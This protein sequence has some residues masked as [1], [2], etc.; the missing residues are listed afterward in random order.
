[1]KKYGM[2]I[3][4]LVVIIITFSI[5]YYEN[6]NIPDISYHYPQVNFQSE[7]YGLIRNIQWSSWSDEQIF[8]LATQEDK[9]THKEMSKLYIMDVI[10]GRVRE[11]FEFPMHPI[12]KN[13]IQYSSIE[14]K[15]YTASPDGVYEIAMNNNMDD[16]FM[17][18]FYPIDQFQNA[19]N[20]FVYNNSYE[21]FF[22]NQNDKL[23]YV[24]GSPSSYSEQP[25]KYFKDPHTILLKS[26]SNHLYYTRKKKE[27]IH[28]YD[29]YE[30]RS[31]LGSFMQEDLFAEDIVSPKADIIRKDLFGLMNKGD[32]YAVYWTDELVNESEQSISDN[33]MGTISKNTDLL[34]QIPDV[35][36]SSRNNTIAYMEYH[37]DRLGSI[38]WQ[39]RNGRKVEIIKNAP[40]VGPIR[41]SKRRG[42]EILYFTLE[43]SE[44]H[45]HIYDLLT[46]KVA[47]LTDRLR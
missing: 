26:Y 17:T 8:F 4:T 37:E 35:D 5:Y 36:V 7:K 45:V 29:V 38:V 41:I 15:L 12:L 20:C 13:F 31:I 47:D 18:N 23:L 9:E 24:Y 11:I 22:C 25:K 40:I 6:S 3:L 19:S 27:R 43:D 1:M 14:D 30:R 10:T 16:K 42:Q 28:I 32:N 2:L 33:I 46:D 21:M 44:L 39:K 34:G